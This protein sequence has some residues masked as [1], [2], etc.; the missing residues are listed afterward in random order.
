[1]S[2]QSELRAVADQDLD[3]EIRSS[4]LAIGIGL[5]L[6]IRAANRFTELGE[7]TVKQNYMEN[8]YTG[9]MDTLSTLNESLL[10]AVS[11]AETVARSTYQLIGD[12]RFGKITPNF[13]AGDFFSSVLNTKSYMTQEEIELAS[14]HMGVLTRIYRVMDEHTA[15]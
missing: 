1:M 15:Q 8:E 6:G 10:F 2:L 12:I 11:T 13:Q 7:K 4:V 14:Q 9:I 3:T 5:F